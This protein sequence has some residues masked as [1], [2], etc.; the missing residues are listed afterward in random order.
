VKPGDAVRV[1][2]SGKTSTVS[3]I[4]TLDGD[5]DQAVAGSPS[6]CFEDEIDCSR[7]DVIAADARRPKSPTSSKHARLDVDEPPCPAAL[8]AEARH[9]DGVRHR[10]APKYAVNVN[11][12]EHRGEDAGLNAIGVVRA[13]DRQA[14]RVRGLHARTDA[15][16]LHP[17]RQDDN[18]TVA[19]GMLHFSLR[20]AQN[21]H[22]QALDITATR[23]PS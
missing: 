5:L 15:G 9:A 20:R 14:G 1:L 7:G 2:P 22:W 4:V 21:V 13:R 8:L 23:T 3:R 19:A 18:N 17:D 16:R 10:Q 12:M 6:R 11:T